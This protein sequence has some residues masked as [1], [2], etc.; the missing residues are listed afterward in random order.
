[1]WS[2]T[3]RQTVQLDTFISTATVSMGWHQEAVATD[4]MFI[5]VCRKDLT[6][7]KIQIHKYQFTLQQTPN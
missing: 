1:M 2:S 7:L 6:T 4:R 5:L 3:K